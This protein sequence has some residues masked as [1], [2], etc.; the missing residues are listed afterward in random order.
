MVIL[1][2]DAN[3]FKVPGY[4]LLDFGIQYA[5]KGIKTNLSIAN[6]FDERYITASSFDDDIYQGNRGIVKLSAEYA[7]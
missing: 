3:S 2:D 5:T 1:G 4:G 6:A 7:F